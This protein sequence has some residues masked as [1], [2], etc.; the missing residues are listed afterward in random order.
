MSPPL[1]GKQK[2]I[3]MAEQLFIEKS[4]KSVSIRQIAN[5]CGVTNAAL[6]YHFPNKEALFEEVLH[7]HAARLNRQ[8]Q[9]ASET[10]GT[11]KARVIATLNVYA[12][13]SAHQRSPLFMLRREHHTLGKDKAREQF[14]HLIH[15]I[16]QP[17][18]ETLQQ[19]IAAGELHSL[20]EGASPASILLG[21]LHGQAQHCKMV[22]GSTITQAEVKLIVDIFWNGLKQQT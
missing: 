16:L 6:Y 9:Q 7:H 15:T 18:E 8:M 19:A 17:L 5:A 11:T 13:M 22:K 21:M 4:Y 10:A 3:E 1:T 12:Q 14:V 20:P 2:I